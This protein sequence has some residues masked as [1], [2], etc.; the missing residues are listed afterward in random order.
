M[1]EYANRRGVA[2]GV[3]LLRATLV[4]AA[5]ALVIALAGSWNSG[6]LHAQVPPPPSTFII[7]NGTVQLG[8]HATGELNVPGTVP[9][10][11]SLTTFVGLR[12]LF[13]GIE[14]P[15]PPSE[16]TAPGCLCEGWGVG[17]AD[18]A[19]GMFSGWANRASGSSGL[20]AESASV[21]GDGT[22]TDSVGS[23][24]TS[25]VTTA[26]RLRV[27][28]NYHPSASPNLY[29]VDVTIQ[30]FG[31]T[32]IGDLRYR[33]VMDWDIAP[34]TFWEWVNTNI[35]NAT[36]LIRATSDGFATSNPLSVTPPAAGA[37][38]TTL[39]PAGTKVYEGGPT[40]QGALFDFGFGALPAGASK[41]FTIYYGGA[42]NRA[43]AL[44]AIAAV[45]AEVFSIAMPS[46]SP[47]PTI[48]PANT[49]ENTFIFAFGEV[50]GDPVPVEGDL[51]MEDDPATE[52]NEEGRPNGIDEDEDGVVDDGCFVTQQLNFSPDNPRQTAAFTELGDVR[53]TALTLDHRNGVLRPFSAIIVATIE[54][55]EDISFSGAFP[56]DTVCSANK[57]EDSDE[58]GPCVKFEV[59]TE[60]EAGVDYVGG[61]R[62]VQW[63]VDWFQPAE[64]K[65]PESFNAVMG[66]SAGCGQFNQSILDHIIF[67]PGEDPRGVGYTD[68]YGSCVIMGVA[69]K[70]D[71]PAEVDQCHADGT[72]NGIDEDEDGITDDGCVVAE[73]FTFSPG[74]TSHEFDFD[75]AGKQTSLNLDHREGIET[76]FELTVKARI[77][78]P[79]DLTFG[80]DFGPGTRCAVYNTG[81][82]N[83]NDP[84]SPLPCVEYEIDG[85][86]T[87]YGPGGKEVQWIVTYFAPLTESQRTIAG[88]G[89]SPGCNKTYLQ[90]ILDTFEIIPG[91]DADPRG[92]GY[93]DGY[94]SC[95]VMTSTTPPAPV[96][97]VPDD[98]VVPAT[99][100]AGAAVSFSATAT[101]VID[102]I[103]TDFPAQCTSAPTAGLVSGST[104]PI[105]KT[106]LTCT[107]TDSA[108]QTTPP[109]S[110]N[111]TVAC[112]SVGLTVN[113]TSARRGQ[114]VNLTGFVRNFSNKHQLVVVKFDLMSP[115]Q[116]AMGSFPLILLA[117]TNISLTLPFKIPSGAKTGVYRVRFRTIMSD[118]TTVETFTQF[119]V[120][121]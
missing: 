113:P 107:A 2:S 32:P 75:V 35:G 120:L 51:C 69:P 21:S 47:A 38:A 84:E 55:P 70:P 27:T 7:D 96:L 71:V 85:D 44:S 87:G 111:V 23:S 104:F 86:A 74:E 42:A 60:A 54:N 76:P 93:T 79:A 14:I 119:T 43:Q 41:T 121:P 17:N 33:R 80:G 20:V 66:Y 10:R 6:S 95:V 102:G 4:A 101:G 48:A 82:D 31:E 24:M 25:V 118:G 37:P 13:P 9:S 59:Q 100:M 40:D 108:G 103:L 112:C 68:G 89:Y 61:A 98:I 83:T 53:D 56:P 62:S 64:Q 88:M 19:T 12:F 72:P 36:D 67:P 16:A 116:S 30:N 81:G 49:N 45:K 50:G 5:I 105:G 1:E 109:D 106:T 78:N 65:N 58:T 117:K 46:M 99:S 15:P 57:I 11:Q 3:R 39:T 110:F 28:H 18:A 115:T 97:H 52:V 90:N 92:V 34:T 22:R 29:R 73:E 63:T 26:G 77:V 94:G 91:D 8:I 114:T